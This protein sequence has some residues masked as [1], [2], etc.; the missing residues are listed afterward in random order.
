MMYYVIFLFFFIV[1]IIALFVAL[2]PYKLHFFSW[3]YCSLMRLEP[4]IY[5]LPA[6]LRFFHVLTNHRMC[7]IRG[8][9]GSYKSTL[10]AWLCFFL[11]TFEDEFGRT[12]VKRVA[13]NIWHRWPRPTLDQGADNCVLWFDELGEFVDSRAWAKNDNRYWAGLRKLRSVLI[14]SSKT[15]VD[16]RLAELW[17][18]RTTEFPFGFIKNAIFFK[19]GYDSGEEVDG[20]LFFIFK[21]WVVWPFY[22]TSAYPTSDG[23]ILDLLDVSITRAQM[24]GLGDYKAFDFPEDIVSLMSFLKT[25][26]KPAIDLADK[27]RKLHQEWVNE[28]KPSYNYFQTELRTYQGRWRVLHDTG[29]L[30]A[31]EALFLLNQ[32]QKLYEVAFEVGDPFA[33]AILL[34]W[35]EQKDF[36]EQLTDSF[37]EILDE[38]LSDETDP[39]RP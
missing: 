34:A 31:R 21:H 35:N 17:V 5:P 28:G 2:V 39:F 12:Y 7:Y 25:G 13:S 27:V 15:P 18:Q 4:G 19:W 33:E 10:A 1:G 30:E 3:L 22:P 23:G 9:L 24:L 37:A 16:K 8:Q 26:D 11:L 32:M 20:G 29:D 14:G 38:V 6:A 36:Y